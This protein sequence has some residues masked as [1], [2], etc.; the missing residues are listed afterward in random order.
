ML[1]G[2]SLV[3]CCRLLL[4]VF[5]VRVCDSCCCLC[6]SLLFVC[7]AVACVCC[8][9][10]KCCMRESVFVFGCVLLLFVVNGGVAVVCSLVC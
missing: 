9:C 8:G 2:L 7:V 4:C 10:R 6:L 1:L 3:F 5:V